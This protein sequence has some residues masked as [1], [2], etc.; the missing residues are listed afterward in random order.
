MKSAPVVQTLYC[1]GEL[2]GRLSAIGGPIAS[3]GEIAGFDGI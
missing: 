2:A 1:H 3:V